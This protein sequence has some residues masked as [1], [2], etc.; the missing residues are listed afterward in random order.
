MN[1]PRSGMLIAVLLTAC[2]QDGASNASAGGAKSGAGQKTTADAP[3]VSGPQSNSEGVEL[4]QVKSTPLINL[5]ALVNKTPEQVDA[6]LGSPKDVGTDRISCVRFVPERVFFACEQE[7]RVYE[8]QQ[9]EQIRIEFEDGHAAM[10]AISGLPG[11][12]AFEPTAALA[13]VGVTLPG[14]PFHDNPALGMGGDPS[15]VVDRWEWGN[16][17]ARLRI[18]ELEFRVRLSV[19][20]NDWRRAKLELIN[21]QP[22]TDEQS[23]KIKLPRGAEPAPE[24]S[25]LQ[26]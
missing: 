25:E 21:N 5:N 18:D 12:G 2:S 7:I 4:G 19:V 20:N 13:S 3:E 14:T 23:A 11:D 8:H 15:D 9:F 26:E 16:S 17:K 24:V 6:V 10:V 1:R 22:L